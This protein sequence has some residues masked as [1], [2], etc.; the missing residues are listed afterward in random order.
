M[1]FLPAGTSSSSPRVRSSHCCDVSCGHGPSGS[2]TSNEAVLTSRVIQDK[3]TTTASLETGDY[4]AEAGHLQSPDT[5]RRLNQE[6]DRLKRRL[7]MRPTLLEMPV[8]SLTFDQLDRL[9]SG[10]NF[11][12]M[13]TQL[14]PVAYSDI[15]KIP[16]LN[17]HQIECA[18]CTV[19]KSCSRIDWISGDYVFGECKF[20]RQC[21]KI[22][23]AMHVWSYLQRPETFD[24]WLAGV[25]WAKLGSRLTISS[26]LQEHRIPVDLAEC[27][28]GSASGHRAVTFK[29]RHNWG[30]YKSRSSHLLQF[31]RKKSYIVTCHQDGSITSKIWQ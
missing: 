2:G 19:L 23:I 10:M 18:V 6:A 17:L 28:V 20:A 1:A 25:E 26:I 7:R 9:T 3:T 8:S 29:R 21:E 13:C 30:E 15:S 16:I 12:T 22:A 27:R 14:E 5:V 11:R 31:A 4:P 24:S